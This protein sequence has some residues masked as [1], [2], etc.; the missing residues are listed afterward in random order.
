MLRRK[1]RFMLSST[2]LITVGAINKIENIKVKKSANLALKLNLDFF[3][4]IRKL[5]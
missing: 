1:E 3:V 5:F 4:K 2:T